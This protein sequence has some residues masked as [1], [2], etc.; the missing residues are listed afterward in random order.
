MI[1]N[2]KFIYGHIPR[3]A[4]DACAE[5]FKVFEKQLSLT[6]DPND[7]HKHDPFWQRDI[8]DKKIVMTIRRLPAWYLAFTVMVTRQGL[9]PDNLKVSRPSIRDIL[10]PTNYATGL[11]EKAIPPTTGYFCNV[12]DRYIR[13]FTNDLKIEVD[14]WLR[15]E[16]LKSD[17]FGFVSGYLEPGV[18]QIKQINS[19]PNRTRNYNHDPFHHW[20]PAQIVK[21]Y[22]NNPLWASVEE[23]VYGN[24]LKW[25][26]ILPPPLPA[27]EFWHGEQCCA[28][29]QR[30]PCCTTEP[31]D[32][33][34]EEA[35]VHGVLR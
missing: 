14:A 15:T 11:L 3:T 27:P 35:R 30:M 21:M 19:V 28:G 23:K 32:V 34:G 18:R 26:E 33:P 13:H 5:Y 1:W 31:V 17:V 22:E 6:F 20:T 8:T 10:E 16:N 29:Q 12:A 2:D 4:G 7:H 25:D 9:W 24:L